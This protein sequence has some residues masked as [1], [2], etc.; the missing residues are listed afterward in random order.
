MELRPAH[1]GCSGW[2]YASWRGGEFYPERL[3]PK[4][5]LEHYATQ[6]DTVELNTTYYRLSKAEYAARWVDQT[7]DHFTFA[8]KAS[9]FLI[10]VKKLRDLDEGVAKFYAGIQPL[11]DAGKLGP[12]LWQL[13]PWFQRDEGTLARAA[14]ESFPPG[15]HCVE[16]R[17]PS[18]YHEDVYAMLRELGLALTI[19]HTPKRPY[20]SAPDV[21]LT[22][23]WTFLRFHHGER[24]RRGN[25]SQTELEEWAAR[26]QRIREQAEIY[27]YFNNDWEV[28]APRNARV[29]KRLL[30][31]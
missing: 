17:H 4:R 2:N 23:D 16:F 26:I 30:G 28:F 27:I 8:A 18:W 12:V 1:L 15:R 20:T 9:R 6:F 19:A 25:Y 31:I 29:M 10:N 13:P 3:P 14:A 7:P 24:G 22:T 21:P 5:W 11:V